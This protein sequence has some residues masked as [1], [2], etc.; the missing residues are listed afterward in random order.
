MFTL[1]TGVMG[2]GELQSETSDRD[3]CSSFVTESTWP[4]WGIPSLPT[5]VSGW[6]LSDS[7][8]SGGRLVSRWRS[9]FGFF[10]VPP[11]DAE[12][13]PCAVALWFLCSACGSGW[14]V[15][16]VGHT[17]ATFRLIR[18]RSIG[19]GTSHRSGHV[20][21]ALNVKER[22]FSALSFRLPRSSALP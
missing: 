15:V 1:T 21:S 16:V 3:P 19:Q 11:E 17:Q 7:M 20:S 5:Y 6:I 10:Q 9:C 2:L 8:D 4:T 12:I 22:G 13:N 14:R 18:S